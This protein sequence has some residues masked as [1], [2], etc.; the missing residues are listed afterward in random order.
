MATTGWTTYQLR[1]QMF[2]IG[3]DFWVA[4]A[5][6][7]NVYKVDGKVLT[8]SQTFALQDANG[9]ELA[10]M[11]AEMLTLRKTMDI[12]RGGQVVAVVKKAL[13][14]IL[15]QHFD[16]EVSGGGVLEAQGDILNHEFQV[17]AGGQVVATV[18]R[19]WFVGDM[20][21]GVAIAPGQD[22][23]LLLCVAI[24]IDEMSESDRR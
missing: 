4:N 19:Q 6:G 23:V 20:F 10:T 21:Y 13:F 9:N 22:E 16:V 8:L 12:K 17:T 3:E 2:S 5:A 11:K 7:E 1:R 24:C 15:S 18:S 14:N